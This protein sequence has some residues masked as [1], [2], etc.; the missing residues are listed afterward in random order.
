M[1]DPFWY[2]EQQARESRW[3]KRLEQQ[4]RFEPPTQGDVEAALKVNGV[5]VPAEA[6]KPEERS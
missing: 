3:E 2:G 5:V 1:N 4:K 6:E